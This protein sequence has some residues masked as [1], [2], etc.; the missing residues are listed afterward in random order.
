MLGCRTS[1]VA[2]VE[3][4]LN[5]AAQAM[6]IS[7]G[8]AVTQGTNVGVLKRKLQ[9][10]WTIHIAAQ[11]ITHVA[12]VTVTQGSTTG[13]LKKGVPNKWTLAITS[14]VIT[15]SIGAVVKQGTK[16]GTLATALVGATTEVVIVNAGGS[17]FV[18]TENLIV[19]STTVVAANIAT[20]TGTTTVIVIETNAL[21]TFAT[22]ADV[23]VGVGSAAPATIALAN[24]QSVTNT[25]KTTRVIIETAKGN[26]FVASASI[27]IADTTV[28]GANVQSVTNSGSTGACVNHHDVSMNPH[29]GRFLRLQIL[30]TTSVGG[31]S[32]S[33][34]EQDIKQQQGVDV[35]KYELREIMVK[36]S[37]C[38]HDFESGTTTGLVTIDVGAHGQT[39]SSLVSGSTLGTYGAGGVVPMNAPLIAPLPSSSSKSYTDSPMISSFNNVDP[40]LA[41]FVTSAGLSVT[42]DGSTVLT[43]VALA[44]SSPKIGMLNS[45]G[46]VIYGND[47]DSLLTDGIYTES[48]TLALTFTGMRR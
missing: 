31:S 42:V 36:G 10:E 40:A 18:S 21:T 8:A 12:G 14:Q 39:T 35:I 30:S 24:I 33:N 22:D 48:G 34:N 16:T 17:T 45:T 37:V 32:I 9:N 15:E 44:A 4:T 5:I 27:L 28:T 3:W 7:A 2:T 25:G 20:A 29:R 47:I 38:E 13:K 43:T 46:D 26:S 41:S 1:D 6:T 23:V 19:G 11:A